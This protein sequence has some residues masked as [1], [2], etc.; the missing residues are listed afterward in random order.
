MFLDGVYY[1]CEVFYEGSMPKTA[2]E[3]DTSKKSDFDIVLDKKSKKFEVGTGRQFLVKWECMKY[4]KNTYEF[5]RDL[6]LADIEYKDALKE[7]YKRTTKPTKTQ[8]KQQSKDADQAMR[9]CYKLFG[10]NTDVNEE[11]RQKEVKEYQ[12]ELAG[13][14]FKNGGQL[15]DYQAEGVAWFL[16][17]Y[18]NKRSCILADEMGLGKV[19]VSI[20]LLFGRRLLAPF[21][22]HR[23]TNGTPKYRL[24]KRPLLSI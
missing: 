15:R 18:L 12:K 4:S 7:Y 17:N 6:L 3:E 11:K 14:V 21:V 8:L 22:S 23:K 20:L 2:E 1:I 13:H 5:E 10:D 9:I 19:R 16:S 24:S